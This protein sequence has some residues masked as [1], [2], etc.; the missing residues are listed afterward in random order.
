LLKTKL[1]YKEQLL[2]ISLSLLLFTPFIL[3]PTFTTTSILSGTIAVLG[4]FQTFLTR[5]RFNPCEI[6][7]LGSLLGL[8]YLTRTYGIRS[9]IVLSIL[10]IIAFSSELLIQRFKAFSKYKDVISDEYLSVT[11]GISANL[12][13]T[14]VLKKI[15]RTIAALVLLL[16]P[17]SAILLSDFF[18]GISLSQLEK[19]FT[20]YQFITGSFRGYPVISE[21]LRQ[22]AT[23]IQKLNGW[24]ANDIE[25]WLGSMS[26][27]ET[28][29]SLGNAKHLTSI[30]AT[31]VYEPVV[32]PREAIDRSYISLGFV[33]ELVFCLITTALVLI[34]RCNNRVRHFV[35][36][37]IFGLFLTF[38][39]M[40]GFMRL[41]VRVS[42]PLLY[43]GSLTLFL[44]AYTL[45]PEEATDSLSKAPKNLL[46]KLLSSLCVGI[47]LISTYF[48][49]H[50]LFFQVA[51]QADYILR[52]H[53]DKLYIQAKSDIVFFGLPGGLPTCDQAD[54]LEANPFPSN[55]IISTGG[56]STFSRPF[57]K[58]LEE[59][60]FANGR[61]LLLKAVN[62]Q[63]IHF[64][65]K[66]QESMQQQLVMK[67]L[68][69]FLE[70]TY[71]FQ[72]IEFTLQGK[73][74]SGSKYYAIR[75]E[76]TA[77]DKTDDLKK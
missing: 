72:K 17:L 36:A 60:G 29:F 55:G 38:T 62:N 31:S 20:A 41:P 63:K 6:L 3:T 14:K 2:L 50:N 74:P 77:Y 27:D 1:T 49:G 58:N 8:S 54:P 64:I 73:I 16:A 48:Y 39:Y 45:Q 32:S 26:F 76:N 10:I 43:T 70:E 61:E 12:Q 22:K 65:E 67:R 28:K 4:I 47:L 18:L 68:R 24:T 13:D 51:S 30:I 35:L 59:L 5:K 56:W 69:T 46:K 57:Y 21:L 7:F 44:R 23:L 52:C 25:L 11:S 40:S 19:D 42:T 34:A 33:K 53:S 75:A 37:Y 66:H 9:T 15:L 71:G